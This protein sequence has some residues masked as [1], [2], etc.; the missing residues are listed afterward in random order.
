MS[1]AVA[2]TSQSVA[3]KVAEMLGSV[4][5]TSPSAT[6]SSEPTNAPVSPLRHPECVPSIELRPSLALGAA[7]MVFSGHTT[8]LMMCG[9]IFKRYCKAKWL[10]TKVHLTR[11][12]NCSVI[13]RPR[14]S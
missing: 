5:A 3:E 4:N 1:T 13:T 2:E 8:C 6:K 9:M 14:G 7:D 11:T 12:R 10:S